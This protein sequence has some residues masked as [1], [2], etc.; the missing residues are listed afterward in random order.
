MARVP[1][2]HVDD[3]AGL[4]ARLRSARVEAGLSQAELSFPG[5]SAA[6]ISRIEAGERVPSLQVIRRLVLRLGV[7]EDYLTGAAGSQDVAPKLVD[8]EIALRLGQIEDAEALYRAVLE[9]AEH[10]PTRA[11]ALEGLGCATLQLGRAREAIG[12]LEEALDGGRPSDR[13]RLADSLRRAY[14]T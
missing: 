6:Y 4:A 8:A 2:L 7:S 3:P 9:T 10:G 5:C 12:L 13:P 11:E 1:P 14:A